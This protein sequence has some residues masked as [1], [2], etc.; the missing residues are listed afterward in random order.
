MRNHSDTNL[1]FKNETKL[2][3]DFSNNANTVL[4]TYS[5]KT[6][7]N[8]FNIFHFKKSVAEGGHR[9]FSKPF[10]GALTKYFLYD[11]G[12]EI[13]DSEAGAQLQNR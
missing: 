10:F 8:Y 9:T 4:L 5:S 11:L 12:V 7:L 2:F 13:N 1:L 6:R 3:G